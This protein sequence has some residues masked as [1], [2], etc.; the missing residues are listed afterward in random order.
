MQSHEIF[1]GSLDISSDTIVAVAYG[2][3]QKRRIFSSSVY[4][5]ERNQGG[6]NNWGE[7]KKIL[8]RNENNYF[9]QPIVA[10]DRD[11]IVVT[12]KNLSRSGSEVSDSSAYIFERNQGG[13]NNWGE[14]KRRIV[15]HERTYPLEPPLAISG[16]ILVLGSERGDFDNDFLGSAYIFEPKPT[17]WDKKQIITL[18]FC[19]GMSADSTWLLEIH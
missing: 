8:S 12:S 15:V 4:I 1:G 13:I 2:E 5:F 19:L 11:T 9:S 17:V 18:G 16:D 14:A 7:V 10:I 6:P 3:R